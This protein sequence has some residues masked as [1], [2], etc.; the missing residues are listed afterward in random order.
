MT[1][2]MNL[3]SAG[4]ARVRLGRR[5]LGGIWFRPTVA[6]VTRIL[7]YFTLQVTIV[8]IVGCV[9]VFAVIRHNLG[10]SQMGSQAFRWHLWQWTT[11]TCQHFTAR[12]AC[13][14]CRPRL[15]VWRAL[16]GRGVAMAFVY[17]EAHGRRYTGL[18]G[19]STFMLWPVYRPFGF[20]GL[21]NQTWVLY[22]GVIPV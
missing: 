8:S 1:T 5:R 9:D 6:I 3:A 18:S 16:I 2:A 10:Q 22:T 19:Q 14:T 20:K 17:T 15:V 11:H 7:T 12:H 21:S 13:I 4:L